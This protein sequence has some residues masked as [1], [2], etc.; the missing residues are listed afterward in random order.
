MANDKKSIENFSHLIDKIVIQY[1]K[2][3][4]IDF[5]TTHSFQIMNE[6]MNNL[7][8]KF[9]T[10]ISLFEEIQKESTASAEN[11]NRVDKMLSKILEKREQIQQEIHERV[12]EIDTTAQTAQ[13]AADAFSVLKERTT[14]VEDMISNIKDVSTKTGILAI[15]AS[16][17]AARAGSFGTGFRIIANEVRSLATQTGDFA[18]K[19]ET[20]LDDLSSSV[21]EINNT[22]E[23]FIDLFSKFQK[24]FTDVLT[25]FNENSETLNSA[26]SFLADINSSINEQDNMIQEGFSSLKKIDE[27]LKETGTMLEVV[28]TSHK[29]L[30]T[31]LQKD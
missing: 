5:V 22:M 18:K 7:Q 27:F 28:Q 10:I 9:K 25:N 19:I 4:V 21:E 14:E 23:G 11:T 1:N 6:S 15:N 16:I 24:S 29:H 8:E 20:K 13:T 3:V 12:N 17:E 2:S 30:G 31:L 26:G